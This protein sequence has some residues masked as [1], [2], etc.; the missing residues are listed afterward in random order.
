MHVEPLHSWDLDRTEAVAL[1]KK[2][3]AQVDVSVPLTHCE[4]IAGADVSYNRHSTTF[5]AAVVV[6]RRSD[7]TV[8][9]TQSAVGENAFP[10]LPGLLSF[11]E[12]PILLEAFA[13]VSTPLDVVMVDGQGIAHQRRFGIAC[14]LGLWLKVPTIGCG[15]S[16]LVGQYDEPGPLPGD[17]SPLRIGDAVIGDVL[18]TKAKTKPLFISPGHLIDLPSAVALVLEACRGYRQ[19]EP[20]RQAHLKVNEIRRAAHG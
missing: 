2:L 3:A 8:I 13:K 20:T 7:W 18:R 10:Y 17:L 1:Q 14:H 11:R 6:L 9:E 15:K 4:T 12:A 5:Y 16:K 19:P